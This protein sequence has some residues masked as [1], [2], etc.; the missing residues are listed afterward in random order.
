MHNHEFTKCVLYNYF[1]MY[2]NTKV[3]IRHA[4]SRSYENTQPKTFRGAHGFN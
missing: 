1:I 2:K 3:I 4:I